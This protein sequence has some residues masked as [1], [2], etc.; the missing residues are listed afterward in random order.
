MSHIDSVIGTTR[1]IRRI[2][3]AAAI[4][5]TMGIAD[6]RIVEQWSRQTKEWP[7]SE[8]FELY[9]ESSD[10]SII[11]NIPC[12]SPPFASYQLYHSASDLSSSTMSLST[13]PATGH[14]AFAIKMLRWCHKHIPTVSDQADSAKNARKWGEE[15]ADLLV[16]HS[17]FPIVIL[18]T[19]IFHF[20]ERGHGMRRVDTRR[21]YA[22]LHL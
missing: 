16:S 2:F 22:S 6:N 10:L 4:N 8:S 3:G 21:R 20:L 13:A 1:V 14:Y 15:F 19:N 9:K 17:A 12:S 7:D 18:N 11:V 5:R